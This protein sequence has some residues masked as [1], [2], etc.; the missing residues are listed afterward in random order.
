[1]D[2]SNHSTHTCPWWLLFLFD[3]PLRRM[4]Q[5]P[6]KILQPFVRPG[7]TV[8]DVG[9]GMGAFSLPLAR[10]VGAQGQVIAA[11]IQPQMLA[12]LEQRA[13]QA[14]LI[15][16]IRLHLCPPGKIGVTDRFDFVL[17]FWMVHEVQDRTAFLNE[18]FAV[19]KPGG[20]FL[21]VE[22]RLH[23]S[24]VDFERSCAL[25]QKAG[26]RMTGG[27]QVRFSRAVLFTTPAE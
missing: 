25:C 1:M 7:D 6:E 23:V 9:C 16:R 22:P 26:F 24:G 8:L 11:D 12:G 21:L 2:P 5:P 18:I 19:L 10:L 27:Q 15:D 14:G 13:I 17:A 20:K 4:L 3:N